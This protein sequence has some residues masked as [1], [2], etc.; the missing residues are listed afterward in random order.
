MQ[1]FYQP[2]DKQTNCIVQYLQTRCK[3][4]I[5]WAPIWHQ[6]ERR[7]AVQC[8][9]LHYRPSAAQRPFS[10]SSLKHCWA[11]IFFFLTFGIHKPFGTNF[12]YVDFLLCVFWCSG[13]SNFLGATQ[14]DF[15]AQVPLVSHNTACI[16]ELGWWQ[17]NIALNRIRL[18]EGNQ[19]WQH[20]T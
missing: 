12:Y 17:V 16:K 7:G 1:T 11:M 19:Q 20:R 13:S 5:L 2:H 14:Q 10:V 6:P 4:S 18:N 15:T 9:Q 3:G 8:N